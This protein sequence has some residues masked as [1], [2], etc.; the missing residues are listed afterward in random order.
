MKIVGIVAEFNPFHKGHAYL[1]NQARRLGA[2]HVV[3]AMS[4]S[5][6]QRGEPAVC[7]KHER[8]AAAVA[9]GA[10]LVVELPAPY[11][12]SAAKW[13]ADSAVQILVQLGIDALAFGSEYDDS[14]L[15]ER[16]ASAV[17]L[18]DDNPKV[19]LLSSEGVSYPQAIA[20]CA[21]QL[22][23]KDICDVLSSPNSTL[24]IEYINALKN[25]NGDI[26]LMPIKR[27]GAGHDETAADG[28]S[29]GSHLRELISAGGGVE[30]FIPEN[31]PIKNVCRL[32]QIENI[33]FYNLLNAEKA[34]L[35]KLPEVNGQLADRIIKAAKEPPKTYNELLLKIKSR[36]FTLA[37]IR[38][39]SL[40][41]TLGIT[42]E[43]FM[44]VP[45]IRIL[46]FDQKGTEIM[47]RCKSEIPV[48]TS[49]KELENSSQQAKRIVSL[50]NRAVR[51]LQLGTGVFENEYT[52]KI[53]PS[54]II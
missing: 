41:L 12:C 46:A 22:F 36:N 47:R 30:E 5:A 21:G 37:R 16:A 40:A 6:V 27:I 2:T 24:A 13:F 4:A 14:H 33:L 50:E 45:Y 39:S 20:E 32:S 35:F 19:R 23:G 51:L 48:S 31:A 29:C 43:D 42:K 1:I 9:N 15:L 10:D 38:R 3:V 11:S 34:E 52:R 49:L 26:S 8:A 17:R 28:Y 7:S 44:P 25:Y 54:E 18:L 53:V